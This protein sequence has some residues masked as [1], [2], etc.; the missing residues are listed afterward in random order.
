M[1]V[2]SATVVVASAVVAATFTNG[3]YEPSVKDCQ[4]QCGSGTACPDGTKCMDGYCRETSTGTCTTVNNPDATLGDGKMDAS[5]CPAAPCGAT[6]V[7]VSTGGCAALCTSPLS[8]AN[9]LAMCGSD[10]GETGAWHIAILNTATKRT[11]FKQALPATVAWIGLE[12]SSTIWR[13]LNPSNEVQATTQPPW[14]IGEP[15]ATNSWG[16][17]DSTSQNEVFR[18]G[19]SADTK[20]FICEYRP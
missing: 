16:L 13:W 1:R 15:N 4:F 2:L 11:V 14:A 18:T 8:F 19:S 12:R 10:T 6:A 17:F 20:P 5:S 9:A 3:C 7:S